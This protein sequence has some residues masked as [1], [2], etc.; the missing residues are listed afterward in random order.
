MSKATRGLAAG[1]ACLGAASMAMAQTDLLPNIIVRQAD[2]Y[3]NDIITS[4]GQR[5]LRL[6]NGTANIG[7][8]KLYLYGGA[9]HGTTQD[10]IQRIYRSDGTSW[11]RLA[12]L[13]TYHAG[14]GH[15]H[16]DNWSQY[17]LRTVLPGDGVGPIVAQGNK[18]SFCILDLGIY[19]SS[20][21][22][23]PPSGQFRSCG[24]TTQ[25]LSVGWLD[26]YS[27]GLAGQNINI[28]GLAAGQYWLESV[29]DPAN[30]ILESNDNDNV[31]RIKVTIP[32]DG[33]GT[34]NP[35]PYEPN[36]SRAAVDARPVGQINS[37]NLGPCNPEKT[38]SGLTLHAGGN[39]D[40]FK[41]YN[42]S[43][44]QASDFVSVTFSH[45]AGDIDIRLYDVLGQQRRQSE[46]TGDTESMPLNGLERG[47]YY[48]RVFG[49]SGATSPNYSLTINPA[50]GEPPSGS[51]TVTVTNPPAGDIV[52]IHGADAYPVTWT[53]TDTADPTW[54]TLYAN[55]VPALDGGEILIDTS[56]HTPGSDGTHVINSA[57]LPPGTYYIYASITDGGSTTGDWSEGTVTWT[58]DRCD[59]D[60]NQD[61]FVD[62]ADYLVF[63]DLYDRQDVAADLNGDGFIDFADYLV[64][65]S[66]FDAGC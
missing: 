55:D 57:Y 43:T 20:L 17:N 27:K 58:E 50:S 9:T 1:L 51:P 34:I 4:G 47:W 6:S 36:D 46:G 59:V 24:T 13:F 23:F 40:Y 60:L 11:E 12:G 18:T 42:A 61:G 66:L 29:V 37:P 2:L 33:G 31:T 52:L 44:G 56:L 41:F 15:I 54:V 22:G 28:T 35:D 14:H 38:I 32:S 10:V 8:G 25:G 63:L 30:T 21:P 16:V 5:L 45:A 39:D 53:A 26:I 49:F 62:F 65:L 3:D 48:V 19:D 64:F 7:A